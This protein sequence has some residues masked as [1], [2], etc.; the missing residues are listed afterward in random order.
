MNFQTLEEEG[1]YYL[2]KVNKGADQLFGYR[3]A[4]V[5]LCFRICK[6]ISRDAAQIISF[7]SCCKLCIEDVAAKYVYMIYHDV[8]VIHCK[9][10]C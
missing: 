5:N 8:A 4:D 1:L 10:V 2:C 9:P 3:T 6:K 7:L